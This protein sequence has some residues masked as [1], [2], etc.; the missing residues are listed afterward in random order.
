MYGCESWTVKKVEHQRIDVLELWCW[1]KTLESP[2][3]Y[4]K[5]KPVNPK[6]NQPWICIGR[7]GAEAPILWP[8]DA[9]SWLTGKDLIL[10]KIEGKEEKGVAGWDGWMVDSMY[11]SL[12]KLGEIVKDREAWHTA[13][14]VV[15]KSWTW[16]SDWTITRRRQTIW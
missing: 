11:M 3:D 1:R 7:T 10:E 2:L 4:R 6:W 12:S 5:I 14:H 16:L 13:A 9:K 8:P 15:A